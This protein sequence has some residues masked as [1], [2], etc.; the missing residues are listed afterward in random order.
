MNEGAFAGLGGIEGAPRGLLIDLDGTVYHG[1]T[2][3]DG[4]DR[5]IGMLRERGLPYLYVTNNS[6]AA[7]DA[8]ADRLTGMGI[9]ARPEE[10]VTSAQASAAYI[11]ERT[12]GARV[13]FVGETGLLTAGREAGLQ[14][15]ETD[16]DYVLQGI[17]RAITYDKMA[18]AVDAIL[19]GARYILTNPDLLLPADGGL[20]PGAGALGAAL[21]AASGVEPI[22]IGKPSA[23]LM[24]YALD[25]LGVSAASTWV[26]G[27]NLATDIAAGR[28]AGCGTVLVLTGL[29]T[30]DNYERYA[31]A[32]AVAPDAVSPDLHDLGRLLERKLA[33]A[34]GI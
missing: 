23:I 19:G 11:A 27:D 29:T 25:R 22:V 6:S 18:A 17:D 21:A 7:P 12:P 1:G 8:V 9:P 16:A 10:V 30:A 15:V 24:D 26:I 31:A 34:A 28:A 5:L 14:A 2:R 13:L 4:A 20:K 33:D 32:A 3:I